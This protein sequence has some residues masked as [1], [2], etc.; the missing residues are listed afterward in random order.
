MSYR[1]GAERHPFMRR[2][3]DS[4]FSLAAVATVMIVVL[5]IDPFTTGNAASGV[6]GT[7][8]TVED[9]ATNL[10][11]AQD[12]VAESAAVEASEIV[13]DWP[14]PEPEDS[15]QP[16][17]QATLPYAAQQTVTV[18]SVDTATVDLGGMDVNIAAA[19]SG[20]SPEAVKLRVEDSSVAESVG[21]TGVLI[22]VAQVDSAEPIEGAEIDLTVSYENFSGLVGGDW[23]SRLR[24]VFVPECAEETPDIE[25]CQFTPLA[26][27]NDEEAQTVTGTVPVDSE[28]GAMGFGMG[29]RQARS[30]SGTGSV[31]L[32]A[33]V[34]G[35]AGDWSKS[36][37]PASSSWGTSGNTGAFTWSYPLT[38]P[39][40]EAGPAPELTLSY[41]SAVSDGR[42]PSA[43]N[44]SGWIGEGFDLTSSYIER[45]YESCTTD[46]ERPGAN[47]ANRE[48]GDLCWGRE[49]A[50]LVFKGASLPL[51]YDAAADVWHSKIDDGTRV[52]RTNGGWNGVNGG[53]YW[54]VTTPDGTQYTF[55]RGKTS[56]NGADLKSAWTVPVYGN[57]AGEPCHAAE[58][59]DSQCSQVWR[60]NL[61]QVVDPSGNTMSYTY[62]TETNNY[63]ADYMHNDDWGTTG[64]ISGGHIVRIDYGTRTGSTASAPYRVTFTTQARCLTNFANP[65]SL[66]ADGYTDSNK[67]KWPDTPRDLQCTVTADDCMNVVPVFFDTTRLSNVTAQAWDGSSYRD[68]DSWAFAGR[69]V[70]ESDF[71]PVETSR[72]VVLR[73]DKITRTAR[74]GTASTSDDITLQPVRFAYES[75]PNRVDT[76][77]DGQ[78]GLWR[79]RVIQ[80]R[81]DAGAQISVSYRTEC[82]PESL[83]ASSDAAQSANTALCYLV[84]WQPDGE[85]QPADHWFHKYVVESMVEDGAPHVA[86]SSDLITG[87]QSKVT[88]YTYLGGAKWAKPTGPMV[89]A[90]KV[91]YTD[92]RGFARVDT[93]VGE[94]EEQATTERATYLRGTGGT[95]T[96]GPTGNTVSVVDVEEF[97]GTV[98]STETLNGSKTITQSITKP[99]TPVTVATGTG[100]TSKRI[101]STTTY[102]FTFKATGAL[103]HRTSSTVTNDSAGLPV[104]VEDRGDLTTSI[105][106]VCTK[107]T[108]RR[109][110]AYLGAH[111]LAFASKTETFGAACASTAAANLL[112]R[113]TA[114]YDTLGRVLSTASV[115]PGNASANVTRATNT[116]DVYGRVTSVKDAAGNKTTTDYS[117]SAGGQVS[118]VTT[119]SPDPD[120]TGPLSKFVS[121][122]TLNP[123]TGQPVSMTDQNGLVTTATYDALGRP[124]SIRYP[125]H[126]DAPHP[127]LEY[128]YTVSPNGLNAVVT[129]SLAADGENQHSSVVLYDGLLRPFQQ[130]VEG[131]NATLTDRGRMVSHIFY[132][133]IGH[134]E[135]RTSAWHAQG[136]PAASP[137]VPLAVPPSSTSYEYDGAGRVT[138]E[139]FWVGTESNPEYEMWRTTTVYDGATTLTIPADGGTPT[140]TII[141]ARGR[142][143]QLREYVRDPRADA[144]ADT[145][146]EIR[147]LTSHT[148]TYG[149]NRANELTTLT[150]PTG[151]VWS[152]EYDL[153]GQLLSQTDP[154]SGTSS[155]TYTALGQVA[156]Q[157][158]AN[159]DTLA[160]N[161]DPLGRATT[162]RDDTA[163]G[164]IRASWTFDATPLAGGG[165]DTA[166]GQP[167]AATR[168]VDNLEYTTTYGEY[169]TAYQPTTVTTTLPENPTLHTL[170]GESFD[171]LISYTEDGQV[172]Q[173]TYPEVTDGESIVLGEETVTTMFDEAS[174]PSWMSGGFGWGTYVADAQ[175][176][177]DATPAV[178]DLGTT[179]GA[180]VAY[181]WE[182]GTQ[183]LASIRLDRERVSGTEVALEYGYDHSGNVTSISDLPTAAR[184]SNQA[185]VQCF[186]YDGL[187]RLETAWTEG[188][189][190]C[191]SV[192]RSTSDVGGYSP[193]WID[194][195]YDVLGNRTQQTSVDGADTTVT[196][197]THGGGG[198]GPHQLTEMVET[199]GELTTVVGFDWDAAGNQTSRT[200]DGALQTLTWDAEGELASIAG[201]ETDVA[202][203]YDASGERL[204]RVDDGAATVYLPGG[205]EVTATDEKVTATRWYSFAGTTVAVR[206]GTGLGGVSSVVSDANGT[207]VAYV[208]NTDWA[209]G[210]QRVRTEPFGD[211]RAGEAG[212][213][214]GRGYLGAPADTTGLTLLG[215]RYYDSSTG[216]FISPDPLLDPGVPAQLNAYVYSG[217]NPITWSDPSGLSWLGDAWNNVTKWVDKNKSVIAGVVVG[218]AVTAGC[219]AVTGGVGSV[220]CAI[221]GGAAGAAVS[222]IWRQKESGKP[223][224]WGS[225]AA[226]TAMGG[227]LGLLGPAAGAAARA[228]APAAS[229]V[230]RTVSNA[231]SAG[232]GKAGTVFKPAMSAT[233]SRAANASATRSATQATSGAQNSSTSMASCAVNSFVPG[234][235]VLLADGTRIAIEN[236]RV[237][238]LVLATDPET[239]ETSAEPVNVTITG[240][241]EKDL[242][243]IAVMSDDGSAGEVTATAGHPFWVADKSEWVEAGELQSGQWLRTSNGTWVQITAIEH[244]HR[245]QAV[246]NLTVDTTHTYYVDAGVTDILTHNCS[247]GAASTADHVFPIGPGSEK[248]W[249][250]LNRV[251]AKGMPLPGYKGGRVFVNKKGK[252]PESPGLTYRE[253]DA[254]PFVKGVNRGTERI[255]TGSDGSAYW[256]GD[257]YDSFLMFRGSMP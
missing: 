216:T 152:Y 50:T 109:D 232:A 53:E 197:Y 215:A 27:T 145:A 146:A 103:E 66:C 184:V 85:L 169:D 59:A 54:K 130:Q 24:L 68:I 150:N 143:T 245:E 149:Y 56:E 243:T 196:E 77:T 160:Y 236:I 114:T 64:Y 26:S 233:A 57:H 52:Q 31:A 192:P 161:Y 2:L 113:D 43:N 223:F 83:P 39:V 242:V 123:L 12:A 235:L 140:E 168:V 183:R 170:S 23:A 172:A 218:V 137:V 249:T 72:S 231:I 116:Y 104:T 133:S 60:W 190:G 253:W 4:R 165:G 95:L 248:A 13:G 48:S 71:D 47:N 246:Y 226:E 93:V 220:A 205:Q 87:S 131:A 173:I 99:G 51:V 138:A 16:E 187:R 65:A 185:D 134:V 175:W 153:A 181:D 42:V 18:P 213:V 7:V 30:S 240:T 151:D 37:L 125:Q 74:A 241:G 180:A 144:D 89:D 202:N 228:F 214:E 177:S 3:L 25:A 159:G 128:E 191:E 224:N 254:N 230:V 189:P 90:S 81:T 5:T 206:T 171:T 212:Q 221:A 179:Y 46:S 29:A 154:D 20:G 44:Q 122:Q 188:A 195:T 97:A 198:A 136:V 222:N 157:T 49:N 252:L 163:T 234:T 156:T 193:Y 45:Q 203:V 204:V 247:V 141:D 108:Y 102:G 112:T 201:A 186:D 11:E 78:S 135:S 101:P 225:F 237:G 76:A 55:G 120:G 21:V 219:L 229:A 174:M 166:L 115:D 238:D 6:T 162:L 178:Q 17:A 199:T 98:F 148:T 62:A 61:D 105:D 227:A 100:L 127:S 210:V 34:S 40:P 250:V 164:T 139:I 14:E 176:N 58:Y 257:H 9:R 35:S 158:D 41:S 75:L 209:A 200:V 33:G 124:T 121:V 79:P 22:D 1:T 84:R 244:D 36:G 8:D 155:T 86:G 239:G 10:A 208:H 96:A 167:S 217:N 118:K 147:A 117:A 132:D 63:V 73:V 119:T 69:F 88:R 92:F 107:T 91:T 126:V 32:M 182:I 15:T 255:V 67:S 28:P 38:V 70:G 207:P 80:V 256:T 251:D 211:A 19:S 129:R 110:Q 142:T 106:D 111:M 194:Y 82:T 94:G